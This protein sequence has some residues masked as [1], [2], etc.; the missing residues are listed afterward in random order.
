MSD[1]AALKDCQARAEVPVPFIAFT[2]LAHADRSGGW[3]AD[4]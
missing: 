4:N 2:A 1:R 3:L